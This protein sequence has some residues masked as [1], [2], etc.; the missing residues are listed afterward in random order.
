[1]SA[2]Q[3][4]RVG[5]AI[6]ALQ[7]R[8]MGALPLIQPI[9]TALQVRAT[10]N[11]LLP[12]QADVDMGQMVVLL[13]LNRL[14]AP[15]PLYEIQDW[16]AETVL[17]DVLGM[18]V[19]QA[20]DNRMG[21][22][23]DRMYPQLGELWSQ[24]VSRAIHVYALDLSILHWDL[25]SIYFEGAY[26]DSHLVTYGYSRDQRPDAK[27]ITLQ[28]DVTHDG[29]VPILYQVL[30]GNT[31]DITRPLPHLEALVHFLA[32]P[33]LA[34]QH[35]QP[36]L[37][38]DCKMI[39]AEAVLACHRHHLSYLGPLQDGVAVNAVLR[40]VSAQELADH[41]LT[42]RPKRVKAA[43]A[44]ITSGCP[45][46][47]SGGRSSS[48]MTGNASPTACWWCGA[49]ASSAWISRSAERTSSACSTA[50]TWCRRSSTAGA[51]RNGSTLS[52]AC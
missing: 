39:T 26:A 8:Q 9:L 12:S 22:V 19:R 31:A 23:L 29:A 32:R 21:R 42:Y 41:P 27:Q 34:A 10:V 17:P 18:T 1:M 33:E 37:V 2:V 49:T 16:L 13:V 38:S 44:P 35:L 6:K 36:L 4:D 45:I 48:R 43:D 50:W 5:Q 14:L 20:Y 30:T 52:S 3:S 25:T 51:T 24:L 46:R 11:T 7:P 40:S 47:G 15:Q 28:V